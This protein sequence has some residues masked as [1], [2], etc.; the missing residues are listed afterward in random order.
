METDEQSIYLLFL[1]VQPKPRQR[2][3]YFDHIDK[4]KPVLSKNNGFLWLHRY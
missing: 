3:A 1:E 2:Q 4:L